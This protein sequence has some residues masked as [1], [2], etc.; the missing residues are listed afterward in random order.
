M[1][2]WWQNRFD[3]IQKQCCF[4]FLGHIFYIQLQELQPSTTHYPDVSRKGTKECSSQMHLS[5][6]I[7]GCSH[8]LQEWKAFIF[9]YSPFKRMSLSERISVPRG[10]RKGFFFFWLLWM[11]RGLCVCQGSLLRFPA[12]GLSALM[13]VFSRS[14]WEQSKSGVD[15]C[16]L[17]DRG[18]LDTAFLSLKRLII[19]AVRSWRPRVK[20]GDWKRCS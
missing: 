8:Q 2:P 12:C 7:L 5:L 17:P 1:N 10:T 3:C 14:H 18:K 4:L 13:L 16:H 20:I 15:Q 6:C 9:D 19:P 11:E